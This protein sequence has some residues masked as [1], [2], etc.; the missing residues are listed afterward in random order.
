MHADP[1]KPEEELADHVEM[2]QE[3][4][5]RLEAH[6]DEYRLAPAYMIN[7]SGFRI[8][9]AGKAKEYFDL[10]EVDW[11]HTDAARLYEELLNNVKKYIR[12]SKMDTHLV[13]A[14]S[15]AAI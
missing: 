2:W 13:R 14:C 1:P 15:T 11:H 3:K 9:M 10:W 7:A 8:Y 5:R 4:V 12:T 6:V